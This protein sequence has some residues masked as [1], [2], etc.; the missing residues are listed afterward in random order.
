M[1][2]YHMSSDVW[3]EIMYP[4]ANIKSAAVEIWERMSNSTPYYIMDVITYQCRNQSWLICANIMRGIPWLPM[5]STHKGCVMH[6][7]DIS[8]VKVWTI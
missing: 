5:E 8:F 4:F 7:F 1:K 2:C 3:D 6:S